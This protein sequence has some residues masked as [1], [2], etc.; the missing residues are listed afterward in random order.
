[1]T[2]FASEEAY[3]E[4]LSGTTT[5]PLADTA[6]IDVAV[7]E[8]AEAPTEVTIEKPTFLRLTGDLALTPVPRSSQR[9]MAR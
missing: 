4:A 6:A 8:D 1:M 9:P 2:V 3:A 7:D 5:D